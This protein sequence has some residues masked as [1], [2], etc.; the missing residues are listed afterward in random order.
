MDELLPKYYA[1]KPKLTVI[2]LCVLL[3]GACATLFGYMAA[4]NDRGLVLNG[5]FTF[6]AGGASVFY[7]VLFAL[8]LGF[9]AM[10]GLLVVQ[11]LSGSL[12]LEITEAEIRIPQ[13]LIK[14]TVR[15]IP[16]KDVEDVSETEV[17]GQ[18][19]FY[20]HTSAGKYCVNRAMMPSKNDYE[21]AK[22]LMMKLLAK[23]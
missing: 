4:T 6:D 12:N 20:L 16:V 10:G 21:E 23:S 19:F 9:V 15:R 11:R 3:F 13:G 22:S 18:R 1:Y 8:S 17:N 7:W 5:V 14:K 2:A